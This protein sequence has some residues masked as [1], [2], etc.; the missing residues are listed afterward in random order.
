MMPGETVVDVSQDWALACDVQQRFMQ[1]MGG[2]TTDFVNCSAQCRQ[3]RA[4]G[5]DCYEFIP[6]AGKRLAVAVGD[7]SGK[8]LAAALMIAN[9]QA[10]LRT[11]TL[12][13]ADDPA[14]LLKVVNHQ[15]YTSSLADRYATLFYGVFDGDTRSLH[16]VNAGHNP[17]VVLRHDGSTQWL[18]SGGAPV[19]M[20]PDSDYQE[21]T[22]QLNPGDLVIVYT[23][24]VVEATNRI[25]EEWGMEGLL[26]AVGAWHQQ[27][28]GK[29]EDL[30]RLIFNAMD[31]FSDG[32]QS[33]DATLAV[34]H[35]S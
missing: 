10:S 3:I 19:G 13:S 35:V 26:K 25:G 24:G 34:L 31:N 4:L 30:V 9:V 17:P 23:D 22:V 15:A 7:A 8:G 12:F 16:Y 18:D 11:A 2:T 27:H 1:G 21:S 5:G 29:A 6:L 32:H 33:D 20:F 14:A 28:C